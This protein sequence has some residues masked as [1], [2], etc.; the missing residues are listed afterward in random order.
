MSKKGDILWD[1]VHFIHIKSLLSVGG[2]H[3]VSYMMLTQVDVSLERLVVEQSLLA[4]MLGTI[5]MID[6]SPLA[7]SAVW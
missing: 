7:L 1:F 2:M 5:L 3:A 4:L 6:K